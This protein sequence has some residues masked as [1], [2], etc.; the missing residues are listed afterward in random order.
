VKAAPFDYLEAYSADDA[1]H[2]MH[3][4]GADAAILAGGQT[5]MPLLALRMATPSVLVDINPAKD[6]VGIT[7]GDHGI[8]VGARTR[9]AA[10]KRDPVIAQHL[11]VLTEAL[12]HVGHHQ[13]RSRGTIGGSTALGEPAAELPATAVA[14]GAL[15][16][17]RSKRGTRLVPARDFYTADGIKNTVIG[18]LIFGVLS[19]GLNQLQLDIYVRLWVRGIILLIALI[20]NIYALKLRD[21]GA[22]E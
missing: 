14:L 13:T 22:A 20:I 11:P 19:N 2:L 5:L 7:R 17:L 15:V 12:T 1:V 6:M 8:R 21:T 3:E 10:A 9:Q 16:E 4:S 18:L